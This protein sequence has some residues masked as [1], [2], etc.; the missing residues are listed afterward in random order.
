MYT[1]LLFKY[2]GPSVFWGIAVLLTAIPL[3]SVTLRILDRLS[4]EENESKDARTKRTSESISNMKLLKLQAW[5]SFFAN[6]IRKSRQDELDRHKRRGV[7]RAINTAISNAVPALVLVV[8]LTAYAKTGRPIVASTIFTAISLFNQLRFPLFF[9]PML[10]DSIANGKNAMRRI[11]SYLTSEELTEY[12][13]ELPPLEGGGGS[14]EMK[15]GN[16]LWSTSQAPK[17]GE[18]PPPEVPALCNV[19]MKVREGEMT[20]VVGPVGSGKSALVK[21]LLGE[22]APVPRQVV[23]QKT[24]AETLQGHVSFERPSVI[25]HGNVG[26]CAQEAWLPKGTIRDA[27]VFG[28]EYDEKRY[29]QAIYDAGLDNDMNPGEDA[30]SKAA[31]ASG[32]LSHETDVGEGGSSLSGGQRARVALARALYGGDDTKVFILDDCLAALDASVGA[33]VFS[34]LTK[35]FKASKAA[36]VFVTN[37]PSLPRQCDNVILM[38]PTSSAKK[39]ESACCTVIDSGSYDQLLARGHNLQSFSRSSDGEAEENSDEV[40]TPTINSAPQVNHHVERIDKNGDHGKE[41]KTDMIRVVGGYKIKTDGTDVSCPPD[42]ECREMDYTQ[43]S[44]EFVEHSIP[45]NEDDEANEDSDRVQR[46]EQEAASQSSP[47][48]KRPS[49]L[50]SIDDNMSKEAVPRST[51]IGYFKAVRSPKL[52][53]AMVAAYITSNGAQFFQQ[54]TVAKWTDLATNQAMSAALGGQYLRSLVYAAGVVSVALWLRSYLTMLVGKRASTFYHERLLSSVFRAPMSFFDAT[55]SGQILSRFGKEMGTVDRALPDSFAS[56]LFCALSISSSAMA[57]AGTITPAMLVPLAF[58]GSLY[59]RTMRRF[60]P[61]AR[62]MKRADIKTRSPLFTHFGEALRGTETIRSI[63]GAPKSWSNQHRS[64]SDLNL[65]TVLTIKNLDRWLSC[66]LEALGNSM[67]FSTAIASV[68]LSRAGKINP[69]FAGWGLTQALSITGLM[70][71]AIR[72]LTMLESHMMSVMRIKEMTDI[73]SD[74]V[75][76]G[77]YHMEREL[78]ESGEALKATFPKNAEIKVPLAP[79]D[80]SALIKSGWPWKGGVSLKNVSM[81]YN[82]SSP[83]V[84]KDVTLDIPPGNTLGVVGRTGSGKS[85]L[86]L[87]LFRICEVEANNGGRIEIDGVDIRSLSI[88][89]LRESLAIIAQDPVLFEGTIAFNLDAQ[90]KA[91]PEDMWAALQAASPE[92]VEQFKSADGLDTQISEGGSNLSQGQR[93]LICLARALLRKSKILVL[94]EATSS[95]D[96]KTDQ[97]VQ[98]T[99]RSEFVDKGVTVITVAHRLETV[100]GN[101]KIAVLGDGELLEYGAPSELLKDRNGE[102][103][104]LYDADRQNKQRGGSSSQQKAASIA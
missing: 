20:A 21:A 100:L 55:P 75:D 3:N 41:K 49:K 6:D 72:N 79:S 95:V 54:Y 63:P 25:S 77:K 50:A 7:V 39:S 58:A 2:L 86:L 17:D 98:A 84:L 81:R 46:V 90:G 66:N 14:I 12:V 16:F 22:L 5:E 102:L 48:S 1:S 96:P 26:Y 82:P 62:D 9:M 28:R 15:N 19:N 59:A 67:V 83:L 35:R 45:L 52:I 87:T 33:M 76:T 56:V 34:R 104:Q 64:L 36:V 101:D 30:T 85:S 92:L 103:R 24:G 69:G 13:Q 91:S 11:S 57:L 18:V 94:D 47:P 71:W 38:G 4:K 88:Q 40:E 65:S 29:L 99:I 23:D 73:D 97:A 43:T 68:I 31:A 60:R 51:Y 10:I 42:R 27:V 32:V 70:A 8:T 53:I 74:E 61:A 80:E 44:P 78:N 89:K 93:Q 37:D